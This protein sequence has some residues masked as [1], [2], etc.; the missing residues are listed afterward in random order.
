M[1][2]FFN[3]RRSL[4]VV[5]VFVLLLVGVIV[6]LRACRGSGRPVPPSMGDGCSDLFDRVGTTRFEEILSLGCPQATCGANTAYINT[7]PI[8]G[9]HRGGCWNRRRTRVVP[10]SFKKGLST[11][12]FSGTASLDAGKDEDGLDMLVA[13][14]AGGAAQPI[15]AC[16]GSDLVGATFD[17]E[18]WV[19]HR[20][21]GRTGWG[22][23]RG[24]IRISQRRK[25][26][27]EVEVRGDRAHPTGYAYVLTPAYDANASLCDLANS[28]P[29]VTAWAGGRLDGPSAPRE[30][31]M[32]RGSADASDYKGSPSAREAIVVPGLVFDQDGAPITQSGPNSGW[33]NLACI[34]GALAQ[35]QFRQ[36]HSDDTTQGRDNGENDDYAHRRVAVRAAWIKA[37]TARYVDGV[38]FTA[39]GPVVEVIEPRSASDY[40]CDGHDDG[41][42]EAFWTENG[43]SCLCHPRLWQPATVIQREIA[44]KIGSN[45]DWPV[46]DRGPCDE[47]RFKSELGLPPCT[48]APPRGTVWVTYAKN[49]GPTL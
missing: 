49:H 33:F 16:P 9:L 5:P 37:H 25:F 21:L 34:G 40:R 3:R 20:G 45:H 23:E 43:A 27:F 29:W 4:I 28:Q 1:S 7:F 2:R 18:A 41:T 36:R 30:P 12:E 26:A 42:L 48:G 47:A 6:L 31:A 10:G 8:D 22:P 44:W 13:R 24:T 38:S 35:E 11:C 17:V 39:A 15:D 46:C 14:K 32:Y 19:P